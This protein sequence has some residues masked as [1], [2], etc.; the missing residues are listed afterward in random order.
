MNK[1]KISASGERAAIGG[2]L[3]QFDEFAWF[4]YINLINKELEWIRIADPEAE[5]LDDIQYSTHTEIHAYQVKWTISDANISYSNFTD[6]IPL[7]A[8]SWKRIKNRNS[9]HKKIVPHLITNKTLSSTD[10]IKIGDNRIGS[11]KDFFS[12]V[13][14]KMKSNRSYD[15]KWAQILEELKKLSKLTGSEFKEFIRCLDFQPEYIKKDFFVKNTPFSKENEDLVRLSRYLIEEAG[16]SERNVEFSWDEIIRRLGWGDR[17]R[18]TFNHELIVDRRKYQPIQSTIDALNSK[19]V[20]FKNGYLFLIGGPGSGKSTLLNQWSKGLKARVIKYFAFDFVTP[21]S[22]LNFYERGNATLLFFDLVFQLK[23]AGIYKREILPYKDIVFLKEIF[24]EQ[25]RT[26]GQDYLINGQPT[27]IIIDGLDHV[28][29]EYKSTTNSFLRELPTPSVLPE[30]VF[31]ILGSQSYELDDIGQEIKTEFR[32][33]KRTIQMAPLTKEEVYQ[34]IERLGSINQISSSQKLLIFEKSQGHP[35]YLSYLIERITQS[36]GI[37]QSIDSFSAIDGDINIYY[38]KIWV[39]IQKD[40]KLIG[41]LGLISRI[42]GMI[43]L[44]FVQEWG[45]DRHVLKS[46]KENAKFLFNETENTWSFFHNSFK[47]Y[48][49]LNTAIDYLTDEYDFQT[50]LSY[51]AQLSDFYRVSTVDAPWKQNYHLFHARKYN[52]FISTVTPNSFIDQL[53]NFRP[54][55]EIKHDAKLGIEI[56]RENKDVTILIRYLFTLAEIER[57]LY[58]I[59]PAS[60]TE[61]LL[62]INRKESARDYIRTGSTLNCSEAYAFKASRKFMKFGDKVEAALL[63]N[64]AYPDVISESGII[65]DGVHR[66]EDIKETLSEWIYTAPHFLDT[67]YIFSKIENISF[68]GDDKVNRFQE[69]ESDL[70][71]SLLINLGHSL[72]NQNKWN[73]FDRVL[74][75][76]T[77]ATNRIIISL[78]QLFQLAIEQCLEIQDRTRANL[79][80]SLMMN[81]FPKEDTKSIVRIC[82]ADLIF[83]VR[84]DIGEALEWIKDIEQPTIVKKDRIGYEDS[85]EVFIP[86]IKFNKLLNIS[87]NSVSITEAIP[88]AKHGSDEEILVEFERMLCLIVQILSDGIIQAPVIYPIIRR[89]HPIVRFY[90]KKTSHHNSYW[91]QLTQAKGQYFEFLISAVSYI[92][93]KN[94]EDLGDYL[95]RQFTENPEYWPTEVRRKI[96]NSLLSKGFN[97]ERSKEQLLLL[98]ESMLEGHD[99]DGRITECVAHSRVWL[100]IGELEQGEKWLKKAIRESIGVGYRK[101][102]QFS[103]WIG[104]LKRINKI[105]PLNASYRINW[106]LSHLNYIKETTEGRAFWDASEELL[107]GTLE[108][109]LNAGFKQLIWQL[110]N[111]LIDFETSVAL[112]IDHFTNRVKHE[113]ELISIIQVYCQLYL[114]LSGSS[115]VTV[116]RKILIKGYEILQQ[117]FLENSLP[118]IID[119]IKIKS[120]DKT[121]FALISEIEDFV[122]GLGFSVDDFYPNFEI[123]ISKERNDSSNSSNTL[124]LISNHER[125]EE[126]ELLEKVN[127]CEDFMRFIQEED[128]ANSYFNWSNVIDK[129]SPS[130]TL[131]N[132]EEIQSLERNG[133]RGSEFFAKLSET[134]LALGGKEL[135]LNLANRSIESSSE[136]GWVKF[137]DGGTRIKGFNA[138]RKIDP[139]LSSE[140]AFEVFAHDIVSTG[141]PGS[142]I[143]HL[144][145]IVPLITEEYDEKNLWSEIF[146][147]LNRL[148][149][150]SNP[151]QELPELI[152]VDEPILETL[153]DYIIYL[154]KSP[155]SLIKEKSTFLLALL[156]NQNSD[157]ALNKLINQDVDDYMTIDVIK[158]LLELKSSRINYLKSRIQNLALSKDYEVR[159]NAKTILLELSEDFPLPKRVTLPNIYTF[160]IPDFNEPIFKKDLDRYFPEINVNDPYDLLTPF[161]FLIKILNSESLIDKSIL[162]YRAYSIMKEI[163]KP[164]EWTVEFEKNLRKHLEE[165]NLKYSYPRPRVI[166]A[167]RAIM[168]VASELIDSGIIDGERI[169]EVFTSYDY[170]ICMI[171]EICKP[172]FISVIQEREFGGVGSDWLERVHESPLLSETILDYSP[173]MK[174]IAQYN[175]ITSLDWGSPSEE[176]MSQISNVNRIEEEDN[177]I[178]GSVFHQLTTNYHKMKGGQNSIIVIRDHKFNQFNIKSEWIALNPVLARH[179]GW[180][181]ETD[182]LFAWKNSL[183]DLMAESLYWSNGN[184]YMIPRRDG[185]TGEGWFVIVSNKGLEQIRELGEDLFIHK[186]IVRTK[187]EDSNIKKKVTFN[188]TKL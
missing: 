164:E 22:S 145:D 151:I 141:Y 108:L 81:H 112:F 83:K 28:P 71:I 25:I 147:Y 184:Y 67:T 72:I 23:E 149:S 177:Y 96:I 90:Y 21:S 3:P 123:P 101:D 162:S 64:L 188:I 135:A 132:I 163:G 168:H 154:S 178:F 171:K 165:I 13:W 4:V 182:K 173:G 121:R 52:E 174:V 124:V 99:I 62:I 180:E 115:N 125:L 131:S 37:D 172:S 106:F 185:E 175:R 19:L 114:L 76:L 17:F 187:Q 87:G 80:L 91:F 136:S 110:D 103:R 133:R 161:Q 55:E 41:F 119:A 89:V 102:Y 57:R 29:R 48:L 70:L 118:G 183:G 73:D 58:N 111:G 170:S 32:E 169:R 14:E 61:E 51:H 148:M 8:S 16:G 95:F 1:V 50:N 43:N 117:H 130:L 139:R 30:G 153:I 97:I 15:K 84:N 86:L 138:L 159:E 128:L 104:W 127:N 46:F 105:Q 160:H 2:Y 78:P 181:P 186:K 7:I 33:G 74:K 66:Y 122:T 158:Y 56:A 144:E 34:Y 134:A 120:L 40:V 167:R 157:Y 146:D 140:K 155:V 150:N 152:F 93:M 54:I 65:I 60:F 53:I 31:I 88:S 179:L 45:F 18:T 85:L 113:N 10:S 20:E 75:R 100:S 68:I 79:Y 98:E 94:L 137:Y 47:Q 12:E 142:Y 38:N 27:F 107:D 11:F 6:L 166:T 36:D 69:N 82:I 77:L 116:L 176:Y 42:Y 5:K 143:E 156:I 126:R 129:I 9:R 49:L 24:A 39:P 59:N 109:N 63:F 26:I 92:N 44:K 35:L